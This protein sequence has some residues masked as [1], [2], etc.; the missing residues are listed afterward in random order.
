MLIISEEQFLKELSQSPSE[1]ISRSRKIKET[2]EL[3]NTTYDN[4][5]KSS[6]P[7][8]PS[9]VKSI[10]G[11]IATTESY[12]DVS[13]NF[14]VS[15]DTIGNLVNDNHSN[16]LVVERKNAIIDR[17]RENTAQK[18]E[19]C[20]EFLE[21][22]KETTNK[23]LLSTA[24]SLSRIH[25]NISPVNQPLGESNVQFIFYAPERQN[26]VEDYEVIDSN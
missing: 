23:E 6:V 20:V 21:I 26:K 24:E 14:R 13:E 7:N 22:V 18:I 3:E 16:P 5:R 17:I 25:R 12:D 8:I 19:K 4:F 10:I 1:S 9:E 11:A 15:K 2:V